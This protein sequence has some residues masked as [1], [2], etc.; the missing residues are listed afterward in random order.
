[1]VSKA[2]HAGSAFIP[3]TS[4]LGPPGFTFPS[5]TGPQSILNVVLHADPQRDMGTDLKSGNL[6][7]LKD[8]KIPEY[9]RSQEHVRVYSSPP[10]VSRGGW[11]H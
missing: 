11:Y 1:M 3:G 4:L 9:T 8:W 6:V 7:S 10:S 2:H 5:E